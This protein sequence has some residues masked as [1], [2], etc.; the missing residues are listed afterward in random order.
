MFERRYPVSV[1]DTALKDKKSVA[2]KLAALEADQ[3]NLMKQVLGD[4]YKENDYY[5]GYLTVYNGR[6]ESDVYTFSRDESNILK[7]AIE[8][9]VKEGNFD[10]YQLPAVYIGGQE[11]IYENSL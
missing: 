2:Y 5:S 6:G 11:N 1:T 9:D 3:D 8:Q 10:A 7:E 4:G